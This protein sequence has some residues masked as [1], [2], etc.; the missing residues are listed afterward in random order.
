[1]ALK[2]FLYLCQHQRSNPPFDELFHYDV[3]SLFLDDTDHESPLKDSHI[4]LAA[5]QTP[6]ERL[7]AYNSDDAQAESFFKDP[8]RYQIL[9]TP[10]K[11]ESDTDSDEEFCMAKQFERLCIADE[12][13]ETPSM[14]ERKPP[15]APRSQPVADPLQSSLEFSIKTESASS[16]YVSED[17][18]AR[19]L[20]ESSEVE[21]SRTPESFRKSNFFPGLSPIGFGSPSEDASRQEKTPRRRVQRRPSLT[22][23]LEKGERSSVDMLASYSTSF[24]DDE[25]ELTA[26]NSA[27]L[28]RRRCTPDACP[29]PD[30]EQMC[31]SARPWAPQEAH[32]A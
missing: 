14:S 15:R 32:T 31:S 10:L 24:K 9:R 17:S 30:S 6:D 18:E 28:R 8:K 12:A 5:A 7:Y 4:A 19:D 11:S 29:T 25:T 3:T 20:T 13:R 21:V 1:M 2:Q 26:E 23:I 22:E 16:I 27:E